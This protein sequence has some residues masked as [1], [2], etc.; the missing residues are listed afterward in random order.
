ML[1]RR[2]DLR[3]LASALLP[4]P[5]SLGTA[6]LLAS[7]AIGCGNPPAGRAPIVRI[8][9]TP[10]FVPEGDGYQTLV[11]ADGSMSADPFDDPERARAFLF[12]WTIDD[13]QSQPSPNA[14]SQRIE[15]RVAGLRPTTIKLE[16][17]DG[18]G[19]RASAE[20]QLGLTIS[21]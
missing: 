11:V 20:Q 18:D 21:N 6:L 3:R 16:V 4:R 19:R 17:T 5:L 8:A 13:P 9:L 10:A 14:D 12:H 1:L 15:L 7:A 2:F